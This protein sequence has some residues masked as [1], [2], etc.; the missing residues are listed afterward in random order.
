VL[1][2]V[3]LF[4]A[5]YLGI[6]AVT[7]ILISAFSNAASETGINLGGTSI[8]IVVGVSLEIVKALE[9]QLLMRH[10]KAF[11]SKEG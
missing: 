7:P 2:K 6:I 3:T 11:L 8:I 1:N 9:T 4:G 10:Y 5:L